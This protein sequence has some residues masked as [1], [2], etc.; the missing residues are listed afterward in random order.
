MASSL[1]ERLLDA[2]IQQKMVSREDLTKALALQKAKGGSLSDILVGMGLVEQRALVTVLSEATR[3]PPINLAQ[4]QLDKALTK[5]ISQKLATYYAIVPVS[6]E[7]KTLTVAMADPLNILALDDIADATGLVITPLIATKEQVQGAIQELYGGTVNQ[8]MQ[9]LQEGGRAGSETLEVVEIKERPTRGT[10]DLI[11][12][13]QETPIV[14]ITDAMLQQGV[15]VRSSDILIEPFEQRLRIRYRVDGLL[16][17]GESPPLAMHEGIISRVKVMSSMDIAEHRLPQ[18]GRFQIRV[19]DRPVDFRVSI[20]P[21]SFGEKAVLRVLDRSQ[22]MLDLGRLGFDQETMDALQQAGQ[23]PHG[24]I[25]VTGPTG[26]GK[27]TTL[28]CLLK[29]IDSPTK[30][31]VTVEDPVEYAMEGVNQVPINTEIGLTFAASLR[32]ILRQDPDVIMVGEIRDGETADIAIKAALTGHLVLSTLHT[33]DAIGAVARLMNMGV[34][35]FLISSSLVLVGAQRLMRRICPS[36]KESVPLPAHLVHYFHLEGAGEIKVARGKGCPS[37]QGT[38]HR[39]RVGIMETLKPDS[40]IRELITTGTKEQ[41]IRAYARKAGMRSL[42]EMAVR[43]ML[44]GI[45]TPDETLRVTV[46]G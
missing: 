33:N 10:E 7:Q 40:K 45:T 42:H 20:V 31:L 24:M 8:A 30:N 46:G 34:E 41:E 15:A 37:C 39:G 19:G 38:G 5:V 11:R 14:R 27:S 43:K 2:L 32:S 21:S 1:K 13:T 44:D 22:A 29:F 36:C 4:T 3:I 9:D 28:Y 25:L 35:P 16:Q 23:R 18:D 12:L 17:E 6:L 26:A